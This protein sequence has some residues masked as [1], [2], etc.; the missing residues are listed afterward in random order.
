MR[1]MRLESSPGELVERE[2]EKPV[3]GDGQLLL[4]VEACGVCRTDLHLVDGELPDAAVPITPGHQIVGI[5]EGRGRG[6][7]P[8]DVG[9]RV[10]VPW[11]G[12][13]CGQCSYC[14]AGQEN[15][16]DD[17]RFT[18]CHVDGGFAEYATADARF[19]L[20]LPAGMNAVEAAPLLCAG[21]IGYR[22]YRMTGAAARLGFYGFGS[23]AHILLQLATSDGREVFAFTRAGDRRS[24]EFALS[25][26]ASWAG[27][28]QERPPAPLDAAIIFAPTGELVPSALAAVRKGGTVVCAG[29]H[30]SDIPSF[31]YRLLWGE[32]VLRSVANLTREDG[33]ELF[34]AVARSAVR[35]E[36]HRYPLAG[37]NEALKDLREGRLDG[38]A[39]LTI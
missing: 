20:P 9:A 36:T 17:A 33:V 23:A 2:L 18:G 13:T 34:Q 27:G 39:V 30:M 25:L 22:A 7:G 1:A 8:I 38:S 37:A 32:R 14:L 19:C 5:V 12:W 3:P 11:L 10:G 28:S 24:Q 6:A 26:G 29:I 35:V 16:C 15:L 31:P 21:L 4:R